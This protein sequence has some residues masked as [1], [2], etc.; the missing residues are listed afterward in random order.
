MSSVADDASGKEAEKD[1]NEPYDE[2]GPEVQKT[3]V[4][5]ILSKL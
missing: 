1:V 5:A 2:A 3:A 4:D